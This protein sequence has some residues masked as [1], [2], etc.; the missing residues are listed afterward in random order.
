MKTVY[1]VRHGET[2]ANTAGVWQG[3]DEAL[4]NTGL[5]QAEIMASRVQ[6][7]P[8]E[9]VYTSPML[10]AR[11]TAEVL[12]ENTEHDLVQ[13]GLFAERRLP[14]SAVGVKYEETE[15]NPAYAFLQEWH[16]NWGD[17]DF[18]Y[19]DEET[20]GELV[21]RARTALRY[22]ADSPENNILVIT[23]GT[24]LR[25]IINTVLH[26][27]SETDPYSIFTAGRYMET[28]NTGLSVI[29][30]HSSTEPWMLVTYNDQAHFAET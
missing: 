24:I 11:Q 12:V 27:E 8:V 23:H 28:S 2:A 15:A 21:E 5:K 1:L 20:V 6:K 22:L 30:Q 16:A 13:V 4:N 7:L 18:R 29:T 10:R 17:L 19:E 26:P 14:S 25:S 3:A 9:V